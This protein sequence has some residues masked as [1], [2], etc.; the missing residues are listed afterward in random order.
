MTQPGVN[1]IT[2]ISS[3]KYEVIKTLYQK[4]HQHKGEAELRITSDTTQA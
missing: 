3:Y 2:R 1:S 4:L